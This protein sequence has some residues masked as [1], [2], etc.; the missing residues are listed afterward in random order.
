MAPDDFD[1]SRLFDPA[2]YFDR[3]QDV[4]ADATLDVG[5]KR[6]ILSSWASDACAVESMPALR[7]PPSAKAPITFEEIMTRCRHLM[8]Q[9]HLKAPAPAEAATAAPTASARDV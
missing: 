7:K 3:P 8:A 5:E 6:A 2:R 4:L 9:A 1:L